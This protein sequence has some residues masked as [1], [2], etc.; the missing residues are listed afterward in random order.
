M[1]LESKQKSKGSSKNRTC[2]RSV[3]TDDIQWRIH[4]RDPGALGLPLILGKKQKA[5][6]VSTTNPHPLTQGL[7]PQLTFKNI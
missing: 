7:D 4:G 6:R 5:S 3:T 2:G 1:D